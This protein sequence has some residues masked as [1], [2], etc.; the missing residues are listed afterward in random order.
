VSI[1]EIPSLLKLNLKTSSE[2]GLLNQFGERLPN[3]KE[4][5]LNFSNIISIIDLGSSFKNLLVLHMDNC[6]LKDIC[7]I[8]CFNSLVELSMR[9]N[10]ISDL[11]E[12]EGLSNSLEYLQL[13]NY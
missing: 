13:E 2:Y 7:G 9:N 1:G 8:V 6:N 4:L 12:I 10:K 3:L 5:K 11:F